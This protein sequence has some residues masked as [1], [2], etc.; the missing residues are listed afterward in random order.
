MSQ[1]RQE[2]VDLILS[3]RER[4][5][6]LPGS[7]WDEKNS[8]NDWIAIS[9]T[10]LTSGSSRKHTKPLADDFEADMVKAAAVILAALEHI[11]SMRDLGTLR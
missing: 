10:Y 6:N 2:I 5:F 9:A 3:E 1:R 8:P 7:E 11:S 4:H